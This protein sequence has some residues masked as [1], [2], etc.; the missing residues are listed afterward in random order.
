MQKG[1]IAFTEKFKQTYFIKYSQ[2][3]LVKQKATSFHLLATKLTV[4]VTTDLNIHNKKYV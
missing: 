2:L 4:G 1:L 3:K